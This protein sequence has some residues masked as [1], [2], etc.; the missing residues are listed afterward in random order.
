VQI[1]TPSVDLAAA[2]ERTPLYYQDPSGKPD[3]AGAEKGRCRPRLCPGLKSDQAG[4]IAAV[5]NV[6]ARLKR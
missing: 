5:E 4:T 1:S 2:A 6:L 3:F